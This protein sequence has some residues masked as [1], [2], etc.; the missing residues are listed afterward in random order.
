[1]AVEYYSQRVSDVKQLTA[2]D[3][4]ATTR[5]AAMTE[6]MLSVLRNVI[7]MDYMQTS[8]TELILQ[9]V[10]KYGDDFDY[11]NAESI[12]Q[13]FAESLAQI[14]GMEINFTNW[15]QKFE[16]WKVVS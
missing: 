11:E 15:D 16:V 9:L 6:V 2:D 10:E 12:E 13:A 7:L 3:V 4:Y 5:K 1:M 8:S 14:F